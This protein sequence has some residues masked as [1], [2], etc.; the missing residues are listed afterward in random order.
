MALIL[1]D[2]QRQA[3][4][5]VG[6]FLARARGADDGEAVAAAFAQA[7]TEAL[8][9]SAPRVPYRPTPDMPTVPQAC[10]RI[11]TG[12]GKT[13]LA[14]H[15]VAL[16]AR[17]LVGTSAPIAL[18]LVPSNVIRTQTLAALQKPGH[19]YREA[20]LEHFAVD[21]LM[22]ID[23]GD[24]THLRAQD[25]GGRAIVVVGTIQ[26]LRVDNTAGREVYA[27]N[28]AFE[29]HFAGIP[30]AAFLERIAEPDLANHPYLT[31]S[32]IGKVK[33]SFANLLAWWRPIVIV[34]E[35]HN[36]QTRLSF[37]VF[38]R[39]RP[40]CILEW[41][42]TPAPDQ[43]VLY[44]VSAQELKAEHMIKL[45]IVLAPHPNWK[46][47]VRDAVLTRDRL[48][49]KAQGEAEYVR[50]IVLFQAD[51]Q[52][53]E[54]T[55]DVLRTFLQ[56]EL[57]LAANRIAV[58]TGDQRG[59]DG[60]D[61]F[62]RT[63]PVDFV[64]TV[65]ALK[66][67][68]DCSFAYVFCTVQ[69]V[70]SAKDMEQLLGRVLR[71][72]Y[73]APRAAEELNRAYAHVC[74]THTA[75]VATELSDRL[76]SMGFE[77]VEIAQLLQ[78]RSGDLFAP[79]RPDEPPPAVETGFEAPP[80]AASAL[81]QVAPTQVRVEEREGRTIAI[82]TGDLDPATVDALVAA[83]PKR[84]QPA[85]RGAIDRHIARIEATQA[86]SERG[87]AFAPVPQLCV[88]VQGELSLLEPDLVNDLAHFDLAG[89]RADLPGFVDEPEVRPYLIDVDRGHVR[90]EQQFDEYTVRLDFARE[91]ISR[92]LVLRELDSRVRRGDVMQAPL[93]AWLGRVLDDIAR[94]GL[95]LTYAARHMNRLA[96]AVRGRLRTLL[97]GSRRTTFQQ[98]L[99][100]GAPKGQLSDRFEFRFDP[101]QYPARFFY[102]GRFRFRKHFYPR[103]GELDSDDRTEETACA[104][105]MEGLP[106][107][108]C[109]VR[110]L[111]R[112]PSW[113]FWLP[114]SSDRFYPDFVAE[115][116]DGR[117]LVVEYKGA[118]LYF[119]PDSQEKRDIGAAWALASGGRCRFAMVTDAA[120]A[121]RPVSVQLQAAIEGV[122]HT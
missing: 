91:G 116:V 6:G 41:T 69:N 103:P 114:T 79:R 7:R 120:T 27:Y 65:E 48:A 88:P 56:D 95:T 8:G 97:D 26:T 86:P 36:A 22:V 111:E 73:A 121:G 89:A 122:A 1:K 117:L 71:L 100:D 34:D 10:I 60:I 118:H 33:R 76:I 72:P 31:R 57:R 15:A 104:I 78:T 46:E 43:N 38:R 23:I 52:N 54:V 67:G 45:P 90:I 4:A 47:A 19:P 11:P 32:D 25:F 53:R 84:D 106:A 63:C 20:L 109:W 108:K 87:I 50:P 17:D 42:A 12:G 3:L 37:E 40:A 62:D 35:A 68:W 55:V 83:A 44:H 14:A 99:F 16:A 18:W 29:P 24:C 113:S 80:A 110:N 105:E 94:K 13:L 49:E 2:Y 28:E 51:A 64:I 93:I 9:E 30:D 21:R 39:I 74:S 5:A 115:L 107:V 66:E 119:G 81:A 96:D 85:V 102:D 92:D 61:L 59:L 98:L 101:Q 112:Q 70:R 75:E 58:A 82:L 77:E